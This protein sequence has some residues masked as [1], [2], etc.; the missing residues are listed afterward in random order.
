MLARVDPR[1]EA[2]FISDVFHKII[3]ALVCKVVL[4]NPESKPA[5]ICLPNVKNLEWPFT[6]DDVDTRRLRHLIPA[7]CRESSPRPHQ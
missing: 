2:E 3:V 4:H 6:I 7:E 5:L 1:F